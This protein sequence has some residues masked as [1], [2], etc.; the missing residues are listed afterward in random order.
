MFILVLCGGAARASG[1]PSLLEALKRLP[2]SNHGLVGADMNF[3]MRASPSIYLEPEAPIRAIWAWADGDVTPIHPHEYLWLSKSSAAGTGEVTWIPP[4]SGM[5]SAPPLGGLAAGTVELRADGTLHSFTIENNSPA[6]SAK[7]STLDDAALGVWV[8]DG[9]LENARLLR[10]HPPDGLPGVASLDFSGAMPFSRLV[11]SDPS[12]P[13]GLELAVFGRSQWRVGDL[14]G[15]AVPGAAFTLTATNP[16]ANALELGFYLLL[17][18]QVQTGVIRSLGTFE[19]SCSDHSGDCTGCLSAREMR[20]YWAGP[21]VYLNASV[22][23]LGNVTCQPQATFDPSKFQNVST[24]TKCPAPP[25]PRPPSAIACHAA[26]TANASCSAWSFAFGSCYQHGNFSSVPA[27]RNTPIADAASGTK[28]SWI[29][30]A[31][32]RCLTLSRPGTHAASGNVSICASASVEMLASGDGA[33]PSGDGAVP[34]GDGAVPSGD[35]AVPRREAPVVSLGTASSPTALWKEF[36][37][38]GEL[39]ARFEP[40]DPYGGAAVKLRVPAG[41]NASLTISLGW[42]FPHRDFVLKDVGN[43][44]T[45]LVNDSEQAARTLLE[46]DEVAADVASWAE[47]AN[48]LAGR[49]Q[50]RSSLPTWLGDSLLNSLHHTRSAMWLRDG[51]WR[52]WESFACVNVDSVHNDGE[53]HVPYMML[54][55]ESVPS[56]MRAWASGQTDDG[57]IQEQLACGCDTGVPAVL[58]APCGRVMGDVT[59]MFIVYLLELWQWTANEDL[60]VELWPTAKRAAQ[61]QI[62]RAAQFGLPDKLVDTYD[63]LNLAQYNVSCFSGLFHLLAMRAAT[64][65]ALSPAV[66]DPGF[67]AKCSRAF[68]VGRVAMDE[69]LWNTTGSFYRSYTGADAIMADAL[70]AQVLVEDRS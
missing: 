23:A 3:S 48:V 56:K 54:W 21:C 16:T 65:L 68:E 59:S 12:L 25:V 43:H 61:W 50:G 13:V 67:A 28:G 29:R 64:E 42:F 46:G 11:P 45:S 40:S 20:S 19:P 52:Q 1:T 39:G 9:F 38:V 4:P 7:V 47:V 33:V 24:V 32:P 63:G 44:Y 15:S 26:C 17:P 69:L 57:M 5:R 66:D 30:G 55:P 2:F 35:G 34:S 10:T 53:R 70:Y 62:A 31:D 6:G 49:T 58:D 51:R 27:A 37:G 41:A 36:E 60:L 14:A 18:L 8:N 22:P